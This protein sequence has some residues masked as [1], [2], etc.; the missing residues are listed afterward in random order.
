[1]AKE[2]AGLSGK[3]ED[4][5]GLVHDGESNLQEGDG[6]TDMYI[7]HIEEVDLT[8]DD[9]A[10]EEPLVLTEEDHEDDV[11]Q[12]LAEGGAELVVEEEDDGASA[13]PPDSPARAAQQRHTG[14]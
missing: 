7:R 13:A 8:K 5:G 4:D 2:I 14:D 3:V 12:Q 10:E 1:M 11:V 6:D 9:G